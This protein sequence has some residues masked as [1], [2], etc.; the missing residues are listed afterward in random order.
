ML[1]PGERRV[2]DLVASGARNGEVALALELS[3]RTVEHHLTQVFR[4]LERAL[5][6]RARRAAGGD[7]QDHH[8]AKGSR[9]KHLKKISVP[10]PATGLS[11]VAVV[12]ATGGIAFA[13]IPG[14][15]GKING[16]YLSGTGQL[17]VINTEGASP[18]KC[19]NNETPLSWNQL[20]RKGDTGDTGAEGPQGPPGL[21]GYHLVT[22]SRNLEPGVQE[23]G[24]EASCPTSERALGGSITG[25]TLTREDDGTFMV[26]STL[27]S[28]GTYEGTVLKTGGA[29]YGWKITAVVSCANVS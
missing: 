8:R 11:L 26:G 17:R 1:T 27:L 23:A 9:M 6:Y 14:G 15:D 16:C 25:E 10:S 12:L 21:S 4:K 19:S 5:A 7:Q 3:P 22:A 28:T 13:A 20:G 2:C 29:G 24:L 18:Q